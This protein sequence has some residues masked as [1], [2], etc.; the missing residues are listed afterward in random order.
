M[1]VIEINQFG[2]VDV[3]YEGSKELPPLKAH[4]LLI[5]NYATA[6][7]P[8]DVAY[9][10]GLYGGEDKLPTVLGSSTAG[11]VLAIGSEVTNFAVGDRIA[12]SPHLRSYAERLTVL[13]KQAAIIPDNVTFVQAAA[14]ALGYQTGYQAVTEELD[15]QKGQSILVH[16]GSGSVGFAA[17]QKAKEIGASQIYATASS[18][19]KTFLQQYDPAIHVFDYHSEDFTQMTDKVDAIVDPIGGQ[20]Q[21]KSLQ[22]LKAQGKLVTTKDLTAKA[23]SAPFDSRAFYLNSGQTLA[24]LLT[25][26]S[27][28][29]IV[30]KINQSDK[31]NLE[32]LKK[33]HTIFQ[34]GHPLG[35]LV[36]E[37]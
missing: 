17:I 18:K 27:A 15:F 4:Q 14:V 36:L 29:S 35:K 7:D 16:G 37:F 23:E 1:K 10:Q 11:I 31:F 21:E 19:G 13:E 8:Y 25:D 3:F 34:E 5:K 30:V 20:T 33:F 24:D 26:I 6:I 2:N 9:R 12:A 32:N 28:G 22:L